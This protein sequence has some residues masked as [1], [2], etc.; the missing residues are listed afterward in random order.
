MS[1]EALDRRLRD[2]AQLYRFGMLIKQAKR[3]GPV[4][5]LEQSSGAEGGPAQRQAVQDPEDDEL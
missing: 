1:P 3:I 5:E 2:L 4:E